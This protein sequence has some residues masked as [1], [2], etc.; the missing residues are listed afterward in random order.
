[1]SASALRPTESFND[2]LARSARLMRALGPDAAAIW[3]ELAPDEVRTLTDAMDRLRDDADGEGA[4]VQGFVDAHRRLAATHPASV[5]PQLSE[6]DA[7]TLGDFLGGEHPQIV[8]VVLSNLSG[9]AAAR[10]LRTL[11]TEPAVD[12]MQRLLSL[13]VVHPAVLRRLEEIAAQ[14]LC[15]PSG[16]GARSGPERVARIFDRLDSRA[17]QTLFAALEQAEPGISEKVRALMFTFEDLANLSTGGLQ[18][19]LAG[20]DRAT[21][22]LALKGASEKANAAFFGNM[23][24]RAGDLLREEIAALGAV[25]RSDVETARQDLVH[26]ARTLIHRGEIHAGSDVDE[27]ELVE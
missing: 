23:T 9:E 24:Q 13:T 19:L 25:R 14:R 27:D 4:S 21:L 7:D 1:M 20:A 2:G 26:L 8:A 10:Y 12:V 16:A 3:Q 22:V 6:L 17:E 15:A 18:T 11:A 5:W